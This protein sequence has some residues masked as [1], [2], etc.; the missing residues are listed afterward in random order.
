MSVAG[1]LLRQ[2]RHAG[3]GYRCFH[4]MRLPLD[5]QTA[6][7]AAPPQGFAFLGVD[8]HGVEASSDEAIRDTAWYGGP[9]GEGFA[10]A[11]DG[12]IVCLQWIWH[13][14]RLERAGFWPFGQQDAVSMHLVT[15][16]DAR[17]HGLATDLK[18]LTAAR[19]RERG[20]A[21]LYSRIWW[22]NEPSLRVS[23]KAG[24]T[25]VGTTLSVTVPWRRTPLEWRWRRPAQAG[26]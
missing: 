18:R 20:F 2:A 14:Q 24:W 11:R 26:R 10:L 9:G 17:G 19:M 15:V 13:G 4:V 12:R 16:P 5:P 22:T 6:P 7:E 25:R 3:F 23:E 8:P 1:A 21:S